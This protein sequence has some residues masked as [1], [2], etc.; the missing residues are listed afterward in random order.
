[1]VQSHGVLSESDLETTGRRAAAR[2]LFVAARS[3]E[4]A[5]ELAQKLV[6]R[7]RGGTD[8]KQAAD[9]LTRASLGLTPDSDETPLGL[10]DPGRPEAA[11]S[12][13]FSI[14]GTPIPNAAPGQ[15]PAAKAF[16]MDKGSV[17][18]VQTG[19]GFA[20]M[21][22]EDKSLVTR[23]QF[24]SDKVDFMQQLRRVK[25]HE[26]LVRYV[27]RLRKKAEKEITVNPELAK[28]DDEGAR[29]KKP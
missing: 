8:I 6:E 2:S 21:Q 1:V 20:V 10:K 5:S 4:L 18:S 12:G 7:V 27:G 14:Q 28:M 25:A 19:E 17:E 24:A 11:S 29:P 26:A 3:G 13:P 16:A 22:L 15:T 9:A 23:E